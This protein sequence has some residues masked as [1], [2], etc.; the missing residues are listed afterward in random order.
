FRP[1]PAGIDYLNKAQHRS[2]ASTFLPVDE[3]LARIASPVRAGRQKLA[4]LA[5]H[6]DEEVAAAFFSSKHRW[7]L[8]R[9]DR[10]RLT[11]RALNVADNRGVLWTPLLD[12]IAGLTSRKLLAEEG[13]QTAVELQ[14]ARVLQW[15]QTHDSPEAAEQLAQF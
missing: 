2:R 8:D 7:S 14:G 4:S 9:H 1:G 5:G 3:S 13:L 12:G 10:Y 6:P 11:V 15:L